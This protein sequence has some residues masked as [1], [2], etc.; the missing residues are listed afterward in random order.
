MK[1]TAVGCC[2][3]AML[4]LAGCG[5]DANRRFRPPEGATT[6]P[7]TGANGI[8]WLRQTPEGISLMARIREKLHNPSVNLSLR[9]ADRVAMPPI[10]WVSQFGKATCADKND[11][12]A[13]KAECLKWQTEQVR[14]RAELVKDF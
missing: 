12:P 9:F 8:L 11:E 13:E 14:Y 4:L 5:N 3:L 10:A 1:R 2:A 7:F 6:V